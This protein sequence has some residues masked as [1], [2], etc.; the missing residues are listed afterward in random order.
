MKTE[1]VRKLLIGIAITIA[2][3]LVSFTIYAVV[4]MQQD[5]AALEEMCNWSKPHND[6]PKEK[7]KVSVEKRFT[8]M[9]SPFKAKVIT[10]HYFP[11]HTKVDEGTEYAYFIIFAWIAFLLTIVSSFSKKQE[12]NNITG[13]LAAYYFIGSIVALFI[14][15]EPSFALMIY[16]FLTIISFVTSFYIVGEKKKVEDIFNKYIVVYVCSILSFIL[17]YTPIWKY[18]HISPEIAVA[19][20]FIFLAILAGS[21]KEVDK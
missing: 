10:A 4:K 3:M 12:T 5:N 15:Y 7:A 13:T 18:L 11:G 6:L 17:V 20:V 21:A 19:L 14:R 9:S 16:T 2:V 8:G 1:N